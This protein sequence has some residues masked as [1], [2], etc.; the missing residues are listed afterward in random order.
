MQEQKLKNHPLSESDKLDWLRLSRTENVGPITFYRLIERF[1]SAEKALDALPELS[2][3][4][5]RTKPL[6]APDLST[7]EKEY[8][9]LR[10]MGGDI[11]TAACPAYPLALGATD[12]AAPVLSCF[13]NIQMANKNCIAIVGARN[14]SLNGR[15]FAQKLAGDLGRLDQTIVSGLARGIDTAAHKGSL[16][17]GTIAVVAGGIDVI[18]PQ[19][20][21][22]LFEEI[23]ERGLILA[24]SP[25]G[26]QPI[27]RHFP[28]R[29]RIVSGL[30]RACV[31]IEAT[32]RSGSLI[33]ARMAGEQGRDVMAVPG[34]PLDPRA[35][36]S[37]HL[38][39]EGATLVRNADDVLEIIRSF[40]GNSLREPFHPLPSFTQPAANDED[41]PEDITEKARD[42]VLENLSFTPVTVDELLRSC[43]M[44]IPVLQT[45]LL[46]LDLAGRIK[47]EAGGR[48]SLLD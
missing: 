27:A 40:S 19:E 48:V 33:T 30:S 3:R 23:K 22:A 21:L 17:T 36:G 15:K 18:Y 25:L 44:T 6:K 46:E 31:V 11:V 47:R 26:T 12:D 29:N 39:R 34:H 2:R 28:K 8:E 37:N 43:H 38:I 4:G 16:S 35:Q 1:G 7:I 20:N 32:M 41:E 13:G 5:G 24:E 10:E 14:A 42:R 45:V 9:S